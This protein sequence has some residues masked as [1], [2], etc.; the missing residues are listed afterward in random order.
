MHGISHVPDLSRAN[1]G[2]VLSMGCLGAFIS[3]WER[4]LC[5]WGPDTSFF[6]ISSVASESVQHFLLMLS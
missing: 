6:R 5:P 3:L 1:W 4:S 2:D